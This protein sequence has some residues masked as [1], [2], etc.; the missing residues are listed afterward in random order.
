[1]RLSLGF[2]LHR[3]YL[4]VRSMSNEM[5]QEQS[6]QNTWPNAHDDLIAATKGKIAAPQLKRSVRV[7]FGSL[8]LLFLAVLILFQTS[9]TNGDF[10]W[11]DA[12]RHALDGAFYRDLLHDLPLD[13]IKEYAID[14]YLQY[15]ALTILFYPPLFPLVEALFFALFGVSHTTAQMAV[16]AF[17]LASA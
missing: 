3:D 2:D 10:W 5:P 16:A 7:E 9:P 17:Y 1:M 12:P 4:L 13:R 11:S 8:L 14:Y 6:A 15:P